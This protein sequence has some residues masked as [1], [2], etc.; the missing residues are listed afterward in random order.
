MIDALREGLQVIDREWRYVYLNAAASA[1][2][3]RPREELL[4]RTMMECYPGIETTELFES[5]KQGGF[6]RVTE[7]RM[8][9]TSPM[10]LL[11]ATLRH[12]R[13]KLGATKRLLTGRF[14]P[15]SPFIAPTLERDDIELVRRWLETPQRWSDSH[16]AEQYEADFAAF[17]G[18]AHALVFRAGRVALSACIQGLG[19][20]AGDEVIVPGYTCVVVPNAFR[21]AGVRVVFSD[22]ELETWGVDVASVAKRLSSRTRAVLIHHLYG[23]VSRD[24]EA[25]V[26]LAHRR[27]IP[28]I[29]DCA[30]A[31]GAFQGQRRVGNLGDVAFFSSEQSKIFTT[32][33][34][35]VAVTNDA[36][37]AARMRRWKGGFPQVSDSFTRRLLHTALLHWHQHR[38]PAGRDGDLAE[39][40]R[41]HHRLISTGCD[42]IAGVKPAAYAA[43]PSAPM[44]ALGLHQLAKV[45][46]FNAQRRQAAARWMRWCEETGHRLPLVVE[47]TTPAFLRFPLMVEPQKKRDVRWVQRELSVAAG[48]WFTSHEHPAPRWIADC[49]N[50]TAAV[51]GCINLP[52]LGFSA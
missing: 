43:T 30:H 35:G 25:V 52:T 32:V 12:G 40:L 24:A 23:L 21:Y 9:L 3:R 14:P 18:S 4:G 1:H 31:T 19:L 47:G 28:V 15:A 34:G 11:D 22:I 6:A 38:T 2:G 27:G 29:E 37:L 36:K 5:M 49:P 44:A 17:N 45:D 8:V 13:R 41:G 39:I 50:A 7:Q 33:Q 20:K 51:Q 26:E 46:R 48:V 42:E 10:S 16:W